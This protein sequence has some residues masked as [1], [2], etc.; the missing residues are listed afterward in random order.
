MF[1]RS[2]SYYHPVINT[3]TERKFL[4]RKLLS[5]NVKRQQNQHDWS[6]MA[7]WKKI[8]SLSQLGKLAQ[9]NLVPHKKEIFVGRGSIYHR[10]RIQ[11]QTTSKIHIH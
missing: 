9:K 7:L 8:A 2:Q 3:L 6:L 5:K 10:T 1:T 4:T 11:I